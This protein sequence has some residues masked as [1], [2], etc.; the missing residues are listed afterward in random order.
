MARSGCGD[1]KSQRP[2]RVWPWLPGLPVC[3]LQKGGLQPNDNLE[4]VTGK[5][6]RAKTGRTT[7]TWMNSAL[8]LYLGSEGKMHHLPQTRRARQ[9]PRTAPDVCPSRP[10]PHVRPQ[11]RARI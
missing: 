5:G 7:F 3:F 10:P 11:P 1:Y 8:R 6:R 4:S 9:P 2:V